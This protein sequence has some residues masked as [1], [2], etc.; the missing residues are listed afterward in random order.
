MKYVHFF[1]LVFARPFFFSAVLGFLDVFARANRQCVCVSESQVRRALSKTALQAV[2]RHADTAARA[3]N[4]NHN[5]L[6]LPL[7]LPG[8]VPGR[9]HQPYH[10]VV[11]GG[12]DELSDGGHGQY[13]NHYASG[14][15]T[16]PLSSGGT[17]YSTPRW[18]ETMSV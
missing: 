2:T 10:H 4:H 18:S 5:Y 16:P 6:H 17:G 3:A 8:K 14:T 11:P 13:Q 12:G 1:L 7:P 15:V 9:G